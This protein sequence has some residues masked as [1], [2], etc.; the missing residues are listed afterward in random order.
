MLEKA[1][2]EVIPRASGSPIPAQYAIAFDLSIPGWLP[3]SFDG[4]MS[5]TTYGV[6]ALGKIGWSTSI[7]EDCE[8]ECSWTPSPIHKASSPIPIAHAH[9]TQHSRFTSRITRSLAAALNSTS[10]VLGQQGPSGTSTRK[11]KS[12]WRSIV[13]ERHRV[14]PSCPSVPC[15]VNAPPSLLPAADGEAAGTTN[16]RHFTLKPSGELRVSYS[17]ARP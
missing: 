2:P 11:V 3:P 4:E 1:P 9:Q 15:F 16:L 12:G 17:R 14:P 8:S 13:V 5:T 10:S 7:I 6:V